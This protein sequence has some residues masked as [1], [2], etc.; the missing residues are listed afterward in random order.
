M[1]FAGSELLQDILRVIASDKPESN[2]ALLEIYRESPHYKAII[3]LSNLELASGD[4]AEAEFCGSLAKLL[5]EAKKIKFD[6]VIDKW[7]RGESLN[8]EEMEMLKTGGKT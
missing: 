6:T 8:T 3:V 5:T 4:N 1:D 2:G 7:T